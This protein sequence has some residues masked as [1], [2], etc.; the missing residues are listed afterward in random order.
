VARQFNGTTQALGTSASID[1][2]SYT[3]LTV[4]FWLWWDA[5]SNNDAFCLESSTNFN[6]FIGGIQIKPN[7]SPSSAFTAIIRSAAAA[8]SGVSFARPSAA[9]WHHYLFTLDRGAGAQQVT[10]VYVDG[11]TKA[12]TA[13][14]VD[15]TAGNFGDYPWYLMSR[16]AGS[17]WGAGRLC[18]LALWP[19]AILTPPE[20]T[21]LAQGVTPDRVRPSPANRYWPLRGVGAP[22]LQMQGRSP[23]LLTTADP[24]PVAHAPVVPAF[25]PSVARFAAL[26]GAGI[27]PVALPH[28]PIVVGQAV[29]R[30]ASW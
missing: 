13:A 14:G 29:Q 19:G 16:A 18:E 1:L 27:A 22:E 28:G 12:L 30:A 17:F 6:N 10:N 8:N 7:D 24:N 11:A 2:T 21:A 26:A 4:G 5:F 25:V 15:P 9:A 23:A 3:T 20:V